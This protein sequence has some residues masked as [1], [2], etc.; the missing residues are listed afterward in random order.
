MINRLLEKQIEQHWGGKKIIIVLGPRQVGKT[1]LLKKICENNGPYLFLNG[2]DIN[3]RALFENAGEQK[4]RQIIGKNKVIFIDEAQ[5]INNIGLSLKIIYD[6][7][8]NVQVVASGSSALDLS[9]E[10]NEPLTGRKW[11]YH[12]WPISWQEYVNHFNYIKAEGD[13]ENRMIYGMYPEVI[14]EKGSEI[15]VIRQLSNS[16]LYKDL[17]NYK[18]IRNPELLEKLLK[19][20]ALQ[21]GSEVNYNELSQLLQVDRGTIESYIRLLEQS[22]VIFRLP[23][24]SRN[25]RNEIKNSRKIYFYDNGIRNALISNFNTLSLR[26]DV[27][28]LWENFVISERVKKQAYENW[29]GNRYFWRTYQKSEIDYIEEKDGMIHAFEIK[30]NPKKK[31]KIPTAF[32]KAYPNYD[33]QIINRENYAEFLHS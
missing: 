12:L 13:L 4:L 1:T 5:R 27:G 20:L 14:N 30:W 25:Q 21:L 15:E 31:P 16:N 28:A 19:A 26:Q 3:I 29:Y 10:I 17:L 2:D 6:T 18:G 24:F 8:P 33:Y 23:A 11:E 32:A 7:I 9:S 22:F